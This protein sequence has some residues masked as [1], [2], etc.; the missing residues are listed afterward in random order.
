MSA[1]LAPVTESAASFAVLIALSAM[2][3][4]LILPSIILVLFINGCGTPLIVAG[5]PLN[6]AFSKSSALFL[7]S[8]AVKLDSVAELFKSVALIVLPLA[9]V[10]YALSA[11]L[12]LRSI[13]TIVPL[14]S[15][16]LN[17]MVLLSLESW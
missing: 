12:V 10:V 8:C 2:S 16:E 3:P 9:K 5:A 4:V 15:A 1:I 7:A 6:I 13:V 11:S 17:V 14:G